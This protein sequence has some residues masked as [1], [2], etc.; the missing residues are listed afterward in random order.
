MSPEYKLRPGKESDVPAL[1]EIYDYEVKNGVATFDYDT[2]SLEQRVQWFRTTF[3][4]THPITVAVDKDDKAVG[5]CGLCRYNAKRGYDRT[6]E[7]T[8]YI[9]REH[10]RKGL[11]YALTD[12]ILK[13]A[14]SLGYKDVIA[15][16]NKGSVTLFERFGFKTSGFFPGIGYKFGRELD[17]VY[18]QL[19]LV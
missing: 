12:D 4:A 8:L 18:S 2:P 10:Q 5:Y 7:I 17:V 6:V 14:R 13:Q 15:G 19:K 3:D 9:H 16:D 1:L 11:G